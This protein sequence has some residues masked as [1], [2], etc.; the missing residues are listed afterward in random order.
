MA[1]MDQDVD[2]VLHDLRRL[3]SVTDPS[4]PYASDGKV[5]QVDEGEPVYGG[6]LRFAQPLLVDVQ[7][8]V[9]LLLAPRDHLLLLLEVLERRER[10]IEDERRAGRFEVLS[11]RLQ[12]LLDRRPL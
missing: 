3:A 9:Q 7:H 8:V 4:A 12:S 5:R 1:G 2:A 6:E 11:L 10:Q